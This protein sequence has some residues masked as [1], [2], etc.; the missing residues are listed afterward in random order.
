M[1]LLSQRRKPRP[2]EG[3]R[4]AKGHPACTRQSWTQARAVC[5]GVYTIHTTLYSLLEVSRQNPRTY[6]K[7]YMRGELEKMAGS[8]KKRS[9]FCPWGGRSQLKAPRWV[10]SLTK[11]STSVIRPPIGPVY[12]WLV[13]CSF[14]PVPKMI[15]TSK[16]HPPPKTWGHHPF[17]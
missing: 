17:C 5:L 8:A 15:Q 13:G 10:L 4:F 12:C 9:S 14:V 16:L 7:V 1:H 2:R 11:P 3:K 6:K